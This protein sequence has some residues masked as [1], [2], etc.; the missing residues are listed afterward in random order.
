MAQPLLMLAHRNGTL[1]QVFRVSGTSGLAFGDPLP[2]AIIETGTGLDISLFS[3]RVIQFQNQVYAVAVDGVYKKDDPTSVTGTWSQ[4]HAFAS[5]V[6][7][8]TNFHI[9]GP[10]Q[11]VLNNVPSLFVMWATTTS[12]T[13]WRAAI[14]NGNTDVWTNT[15]DQTGTTHDATSRWGQQIVYRNVWYGLTDS[16]V[17]TFDPGAGSF[18]VISIPADLEVAQTAGLG[19]FNDRLL[20]IGRNATNGN[21]RLLEIVAGSIS[22]LF[23]VPGFTSYANTETE[24]KHAL[25]PSPTGTFLYAIVNTNT[26]GDGNS[27]LKFTSTAG[28]IAFDSNIT[29]PVIPVSLR[30]G[31]GTTTQ[32]W[33][34]FYDQE[35]TPGTARLLIYFAPN[36]SS[37]SI[38]TQYVF[39]DE[40]TTMTQED[41][42]GNAAWAQVA[43]MTGGG[44]RIFTPGEL[45]IEIVERFAVL[46]G[47]ALWFKAWGD[48]G[49]ADKNV[50]F[51]FNTQTE[52][53]LTLATLTGTP[54]VISG[55]ASPPTLNVG[56]KR[57][58]DVEADG[59]S[60]FQTVWAITSDGV[61]SGQRAQI[62]PRVFI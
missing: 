27:F 24:L 1:P 21:L 13:S 48:P 42:G 5:V 39:V 50:E 54:A 15:G 31:S 20:L 28:V 7:A 23:D 3:N 49:P 17:M 22:G 4:D 18:G 16:G 33:W 25:F 57:L 40:S 62:V 11:V 55:T 58:E 37:A 43:V 46:G 14:L 10:F 9:H 38:M 12:A 60:V 59:T 30:P 36:G 51:R 32:R 61:A 6:G 35:T 29:N 45:H 41:S 47:E 52:L 34:V 8:G 26:G 56:L 44:E 2:T 53:P 19:I